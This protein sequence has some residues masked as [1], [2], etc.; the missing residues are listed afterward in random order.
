MPKAS[1]PTVIQVYVKN[2][3]GKDKTYVKDEKLAA[4]LSQLTGHLTLTDEAKKALESI[5]FSFEQ[6]LP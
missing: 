1:I 5:G 4:A 2:V 3:Y 6:V